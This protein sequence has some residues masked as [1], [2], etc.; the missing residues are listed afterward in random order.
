MKITLPFPPAILNP[1]KRVH[2]AARAKA[3]KAYRHACWALTKQQ[4]TLSGPMHPPISLQITF[5]PPDNRRRDKSNVEAAFKAGQD[6]IADAIGVDDFYFKSQSY[7]GDKVKGGAT[8]VVIT[9]AGVDLKIGVA[10][11]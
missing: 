11:T 7:M 4:G 9:P 8:V 1:N 2:W 10:S 5:H 3:V 6:G